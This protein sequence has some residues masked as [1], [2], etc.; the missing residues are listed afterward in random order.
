MRIAIASAL[1]FLVAASAARA[2]T[3]DEERP[4]TSA[5]FDYAQADAL[6]KKADTKKLSGSLLIGLGTAISVAG[7]ILL[8]TNLV[9]G[10]IGARDVNTLAVTCPDNICLAT[11]MGQAGLT[12]LLVGTAAV[13]SGIPLFAVGNAEKQRARKLGGLAFGGSGLRLAF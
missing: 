7:Q 5:A 6:A 10:S 11:P 2:Q 4:P 13:F 8:F 3:R 9:E 12:L 1:V